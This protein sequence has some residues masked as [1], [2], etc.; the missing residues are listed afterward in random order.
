[1][2]TANHFPL[3]VHAEWGQRV[4]TTGKLLEGTGGGCTLNYHMEMKPTRCQFAK[5]LR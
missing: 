3:F 2:N 5:R 1:M 4:Q